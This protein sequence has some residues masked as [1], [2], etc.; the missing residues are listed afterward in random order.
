MNTEMHRVMGLDLGE[1]RIGIALSDIMGI[2]ANGY[3]SY[4]RERLNRDLEHIV[5]ICKEKNVELIV[6]GLP[7]SMNGTRGEA[8]DKVEFFVSKLKE[9]TPIKIDFYDE[10]L[11]TA[12]AQKLLISADVSREKRKQV[13]DKM[14]ATIILQDYLNSH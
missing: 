6:I 11:T 8:V 3:E 4:T 10:R 9:K 14:A 12:T 1:R 2:I 5:N 13:I 7:M